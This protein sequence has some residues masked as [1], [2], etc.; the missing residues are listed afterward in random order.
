MTLPE[1]RLLCLSNYII[2]LFCIFSH[3]TARALVHKVTS[4]F[5][6]LVRSEVMRCMVRQDMAFFD[7]FPSGI[8]Q[9][10]LNH[11]AEKLASKFFDLPMTM[12]HNTFMLI[13]NVYV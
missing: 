9:E 7:I 8:L 3:L 1:L 2:F 6:L 11:D 13:S 4:R 5:R 12:V 10:R